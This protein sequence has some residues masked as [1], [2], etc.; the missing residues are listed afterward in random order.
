MSFLPT[1]VFIVICPLI[2]FAGTPVGKDPTSLS[3]RLFYSGFA[4]SDSVGGSGR[5]SSVDQVDR[6][7]LAI[8][9]GV[10]A[11]SMATIHIYQQNGWWKENRTPFH[12]QED[13]TY[14]L[15]VDKVGHFFGGYILGFTIDHSLRSA[16]VPTSKAVWIGAAAGL[17]FQTYVEMEDGFTAWGFDRVDFAAD[18]AGAAWPVIRFYIPYL[19]NFDLKMSYHPSALLGEPGG[20]GFKGQQ[21]IMIDDYE[22][23]TF[24]MSVN[25]HSLLPEQTRSFW[26]EFLCLSFGYGVRE[27]AGP[28]P[29]RVYFIAPDLDMTKVIPA[30]SPLLKFVGEALNF[31]HAPLPAV[32]FSERG[33]VWYGFYF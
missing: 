7:R 17:L 18:V 21:H 22:G 13:L 30:S 8:V 9:G 16:N 6:G 5:V 15:W 27:V 2:A 32:R 3:H 25:I 4:S 31:F 1:C 24:W 12:F 10:W 20:V 29:Y 11:G 14:G 28:N 33:T 19:E 26:P 23:Q